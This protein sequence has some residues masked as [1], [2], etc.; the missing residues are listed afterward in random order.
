ML[1]EL[2]TVVHFTKSLPD[3][4]SV[5]IDAYRYCV[6]NSNLHLGSFLTLQFQAIS[7]GD[8]VTRLILFHYLPIHNTS[9]IVYT[10]RNVTCLN[11]TPCLGHKTV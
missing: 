9:K 8:Q 6:F 7:R 2:N 1:V 4:K 5:S 3:G 11:F 10:V